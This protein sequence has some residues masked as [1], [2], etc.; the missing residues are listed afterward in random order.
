M[1]ELGI[2]FWQVSEG[3]VAKLPRLTQILVYDSLFKELRLCHARTQRFEKF[4]KFNTDNFT[5]R[6]V[7]LLF[8]EPQY[9]S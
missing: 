9:L 6:Y 3:E 5:Q 8:K 7:F 1:Q 2:K 4:V